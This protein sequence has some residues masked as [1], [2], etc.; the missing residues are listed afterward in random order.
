MKQ[1]NKYYNNNIQSEQK[2]SFFKEHFKKIIVLIILVASLLANGYLIWKLKNVAVSVEN[3]K[4]EFSFLNPL[5]QLLKYDS[6]EDRRANTIMSFAS[7]RQEIEG[8]LGDKQKQAG[9]Y[10]EDLNTGT[11]LGINEK[12]KFVPASLIKVAFATAALKKVDKNI[13]TLDTPLLLQPKY[14]NKKYGTLWKLDD[15]SDVP[16]RKVIEE[17]IITS[18]NTTVSM[19]YNSLTKEERDEVFYH[20]GQRNPDENPEFPYV[21]ELYS[22]KEL[23]TAYR[24]L[25]NSSYLTRKNSQYLL[26]LLAKTVFRSEIPRPIPSNISV[27][28]KIGE[29][30]RAS[31]PELP[32]FSFHDCGI[33]Y[34]PQR[35]YIICVMTDGIPVKDASDLIASISDRVYKYINEYDT[36][37]RAN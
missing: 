19:I 31:V 35:P 16:L 20:I 23:A 18:D 22:P 13:W 10:L 28:H 26:T 34:Y 37:I 24:M 15:F 30:T 36:K 4:N 32:D 3:S 5:L 1:K 2:K 8:L 21:I 12:Q 25:Y 33:V 14:K 6:A 27:A 9:V 11:W 29:A 17:M 7:L